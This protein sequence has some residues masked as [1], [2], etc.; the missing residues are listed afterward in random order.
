MLKILRLSLRS[1]LGLQLANAF[2]VVP[3]AKKL[4]DEF[5]LF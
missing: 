2:G 5:D 4:A 3:L 1:N